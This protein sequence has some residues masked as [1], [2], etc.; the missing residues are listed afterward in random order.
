MKNML[1]SVLS[2]PFFQ[3][4]KGIARFAL[5]SIVVFITFQVKGQMALKGEILLDENFQKYAEYPKDESPQWNDFNVES[6]VLSDAWKVKAWH[7]I[8]KR[9]AEGVQSTWISG[10]PPILAFK[11]DFKDVIIEYD[12]RFHNEVGKKMIC[13]ISFINFDIYPSEYAGQAWANI[14]STERDL[15]I[16]L[17]ND[18][19]AKGP[20]RL[21]NQ[22]CS[23]NENQW[24]TMRFEI[25]GNKALVN[26]N[27]ITLYGTSVKFD[28]PK[29]IIALGTGECPC[30][31]RNFKVYEATPNPKWNRTSK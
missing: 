12:F 29:K 28:I 26:C 24:Y 17:E 30:D 5:L 22:M 7:G 14:N 23:F 21:A 15:G 27:N 9:N 11:G 4:Y 2:I 6:Q 13:R 3:S 18:S 31:I 16:V 20:T 10:H 1:L 25:I 19:W 8:W